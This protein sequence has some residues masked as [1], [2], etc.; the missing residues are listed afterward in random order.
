[1]FTW[2][3]FPSQLCQVKVSVILNKPSMHCLGVNLNFARTASTAQDGSSFDSEFLQP[4]NSQV[5]K[6]PTISIKQSL[7]TNPLRPRNFFNANFPNEFNSQCWRVVKQN[8]YRPES[9]FLTF[10]FPYNVSVS[11]SLSSFTLLIL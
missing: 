2:N 5:R 6:Q 10:C 8:L 1:M 4:S 9:V 11:S 3:I 7:I